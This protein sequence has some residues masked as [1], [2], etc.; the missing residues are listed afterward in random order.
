VL[1]MHLHDPHDPVDQAAATTFRTLLQDQIEA[2]GDAA[3]ANEL[4]GQPDL[5]EWWRW[6]AEDLR[7]YLAD[8]GGAAGPQAA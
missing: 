6:R 2:A 4:I 7:Q 1:D 8:S 5:A 3:M